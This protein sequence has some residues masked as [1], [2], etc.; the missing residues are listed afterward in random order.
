M[1]DKFNRIR[2]FHQ[3]AGLIILFFWFSVVYG[4]QKSDFKNLD[5]ALISQVNQG[6]S[7]ITFPTDIG[8]ME[9]LMFE[10]NLIP[11][12]IL[13]ENKTSRL[14][15]VL[16]PQII[17]RMYNEYS[18][19]VRTPSYIP[20][21][22]AYYLI[23]KR[24]DKFMTTVFGRL[25][26]HSNGQ[27]DSLILDNGKIN[28]ISGDFAT[29]Y[30]EFGGILTSYNTH[31]NAVRFFKASFA[32]HPENS[33]HRLLGKIYS[34]HRINLNFS[35][36]KLPKKTKLDKADFSM[37]IKL[38]FLLGNMSDL[39]TF[40]SE[41]LQT[42]ITFS[43]FPEFFEDF[44]LFVELYHGHDYYNVYYDKIR[45]IIRFGL[46]TNKLRF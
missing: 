8:N 4:Q 26:H 5:V 14:V 27:D 7:Y 35:A 31:T 3:Y 13:R 18:Y 40:S 41:R 22:T 36:F 9:P 30:M 6:S 46:M 29:N 37:D 10:A 1:N 39:P 32:Y 11:N 25:A 24:T 28:Y 15:G 43:Y 17:I 38:N 20:Q 16:T 21:V 2:N 45:N 34:R 44:G 33:V 19:P 23:G 12:F 42:S